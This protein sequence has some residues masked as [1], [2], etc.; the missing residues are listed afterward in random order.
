VQKE[1]PNGE[2]ERRLAG[3]ERAAVLTS[4]KGKKTAKEKNISSHHLL[5]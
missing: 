4:V 2:A 1:S 5:L 3:D